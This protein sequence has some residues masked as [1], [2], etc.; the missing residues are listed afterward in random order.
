MIEPYILTQEKDWE[1]KGQYYSR[2]QTSDIL[3]SLA[4]SLLLNMP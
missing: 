3:L 1:K 4:N 2:Y